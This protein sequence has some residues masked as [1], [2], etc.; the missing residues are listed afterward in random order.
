VYSA[1]VNRI[2]ALQN[3]ICTLCSYYAPT[4]RPYPHRTPA[5]ISFRYFDI[6]ST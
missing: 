4:L 3:T 6:H 5:S 1:A 2:V